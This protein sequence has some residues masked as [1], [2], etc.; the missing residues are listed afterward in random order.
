M[1]KIQCLAARTV[2]KVL[3][4]ASLTT[5]L[6]ELWNKHTT[7]SDQQRGAIQDISYGVLRFYG[8]LDALLRI[9]VNKPLKDQDLY[10]LLLVGL[11]QLQYSR[12]S[13]YAIVD[14]A[15]GSTRINQCSVTWFHAPAQNSTEINI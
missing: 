6:Q 7:L 5:T 2:G 9:L 3:T 1:I 11:Y 12:S 4:G 13:A 8:Q 14:H 10:Y 15:V